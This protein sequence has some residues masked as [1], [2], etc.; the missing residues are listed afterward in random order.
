[1]CVHLHTCTYTKTDNYGHMHKQTSILHKIPD[2]MLFTLVQ[3]CLRVI[4]LVLKVNTYSSPLATLFNYY[5]YT[6]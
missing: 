2:Q 6:M 5:M 1:M 3:K 4:V